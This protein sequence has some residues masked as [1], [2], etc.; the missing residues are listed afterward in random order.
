MMKGYLQLRTRVDRF[1]ESVTARYSEQIVCKPGCSSC[2]VAGLTIVM[3]EA[4]VLGKALG[5]DP[6]RV[7]LQAGQPPLKTEGYC[8]LLDDDNRCIAHGERPLI[9]RTQGMP[10][11]YPDSEEISVCELNFVGLEPHGSAVFDMGNLETALFAANLDYC[12]RVGLHPLSRVAIDRLFQLSE[13][14]G[15]R[16]GE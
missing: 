12:Q 3:V 5:L 16:G 1:V 13:G 6:E 4:V 9:C 11:K 10:L 15:S 14:A 7:F 2:C 8:P